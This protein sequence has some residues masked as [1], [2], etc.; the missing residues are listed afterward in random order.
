MPKG[1]ERRKHPRIDTSLSLKI[2]KQDVDFITETKNISCSGMYC[3][4]DR[5]LPPM[6]KIAIT[7]LLPVGAGDKTKT[8]K[9]KCSGVIVRSLPVKKGGNHSCPHDIA[10]FFT[11]LA[12]ADKDKIAQYVE[13][14]LS[15]SPTPRYN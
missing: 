13:H 1:I 11:E 2:E 10:V 3:Q 4:I 6:T 8:R 9:I 5:F 15:Q 7:L 12:K 14:H